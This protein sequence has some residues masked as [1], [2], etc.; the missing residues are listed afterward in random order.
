MK[1]LVTAATKHGATAEIAAAVGEALRGEP[2]L[3]ASVVSPEEVATIDGYDAVVLGSAV[4]AG[5]WL[6]AA[7]EL[8]DRAGGALA[9]KP[10]WL[11]SSGPIGDPPKPN[12]DP[13]DVAEIVAATKAREHR[14]FAGKLMR[15]QL[16]FGER[17]IVVALR[18]RRGTSGTGPRSRTG[19][20]RSP[21]AWG[22]AP[23]PAGKDRSCTPACE[24]PFPVPRRRSDAG[25][26]A[27][28]D[29]GRGPGR[30]AVVP[31]GAAVPALA[32]ALGGDRRRGRVG[33]A[34]R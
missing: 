17:A 24:E 20:R 23:D 12:E 34:R 33:D 1:V 27:S 29:D 25:T 10:V 13:V 18:V 28:S 30:V 22:P 6:P 4:Y 11:F 7:R 14:V 9:G 19:R 8:V 26:R 21:T 2:G 32:L 15:K 16:G 5:H 31:D 3:D